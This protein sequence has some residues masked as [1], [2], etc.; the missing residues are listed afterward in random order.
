MKNSFQLEFF[1]F[2][3]GVS[4]AS[5]TH[6]HPNLPQK[7]MGAKWKGPGQAE[8]AAAGAGEDRALHRTACREQPR[9]GPGWG[10]WPAG[11]MGAAQADLPGDGK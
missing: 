5:W 7:D 4:Q 1:P 8:E 9:E 6:C 2:P 3:Q 11:G 10:A